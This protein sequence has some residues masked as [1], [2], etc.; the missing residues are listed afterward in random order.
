MIDDKCCCCCAECCL[1]Y[2]LQLN[3]YSE[4][5]DAECH[6]AEIRDVISKVII[7]TT[8]VKN[9]IS[10]LGPVQCDQKIGNFFCPNVGKSS[11]NS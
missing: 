8:V 6:H 7:T 1:C 11:Q 4:C 10:V 3:Y 2:A 5:R 9:V